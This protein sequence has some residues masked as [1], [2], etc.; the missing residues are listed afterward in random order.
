MTLN[1]YIDLYVLVCPHR[2]NV[3]LGADKT[4]KSTTTQSD[5]DPKMAHQMG[6][7]VEQREGTRLSG[8]ECRAG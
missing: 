1:S 8:R 4:I 2:N 5:Y 6:P 7:S 3:G